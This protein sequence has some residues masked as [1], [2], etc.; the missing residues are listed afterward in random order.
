MGD[1]E[2]M[3]MFLSQL[4]ILLTIK[5]GVISYNSFHLND[6]L[7]FFAPPFTRIKSTPSG[8]NVTH[9]RGSSK[10]FCNYFGEFYRLRETDIGI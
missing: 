10:S 9:S 2:R 3:L 7:K 1:S 8:Q 5:A 4:N 6:I